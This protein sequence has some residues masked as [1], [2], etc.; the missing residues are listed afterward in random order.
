M[1]RSHR[2]AYAAA[3]MSSVSLAA[4]QAQAA[5]FLVAIEDIPLPA[6]FAEAPDPV[7]FETDFGRV[8]RT[9]AFGRGDFQA[10]QRFYLETLP[11]LGWTQ[12]R[13]PGVGARLA[14]TRGEERLSLAFE[15]TGERT[16][17][18]AAGSDA[19]LNIAFELVVRLA[20]SRLPE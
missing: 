10:V 14:F 15:R 20:S 3:L 12:A 9:S 19:P 5:V 4:P 13:A 7:V 6:G 2:I 18:L 8:I 16:G 11:A 17:E 1:R